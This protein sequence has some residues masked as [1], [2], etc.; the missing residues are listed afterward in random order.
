[1]AKKK[2][3]SEVPAGAPDPAA[4]PVGRVTG[5][6]DIPANAAPI[7]VKE[8]NPLT[9]EPKVVGAGAGAAIVAVFVWV[10]KQFAGI[11]VPVDV[12][13]SL[14]VLFA[15]AGGWFTSNKK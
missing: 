4:V 9:P 15:F 1:M 3:K 13:T 6:E 10:L 14:G 7:I 12:A 11:E 8:P 2:A 5:V